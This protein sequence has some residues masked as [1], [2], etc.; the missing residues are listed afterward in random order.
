LPKPSGCEP[1]G[2]SLETVM[3]DGTYILV[4]L[5]LLAAAV[6][7]GVVLWKQ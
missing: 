1:H 2:I 4:M 6:F 3:F 7:L 5:S